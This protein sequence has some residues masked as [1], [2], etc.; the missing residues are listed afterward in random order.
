MARTGASGPVEHPAGKGK[1]KKSEM[2]AGKSHGH[3]D[4]SHTGQPGQLGGGQAAEAVTTWQ[5][6]TACAHCEA[7]RTPSVS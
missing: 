5:V 3:V 6:E 4:D 7:L 1:T 2:Q